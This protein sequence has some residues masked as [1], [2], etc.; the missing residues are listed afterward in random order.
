[1]Y[2]PKI[3]GRFPARKVIS[4]GSCG[5]G[6]I[7]LSSGRSLT[8][9]ILLKRQL[10]PLHMENPKSTV[11]PLKRSMLVLA[12][13]NPHKRL[14]VLL[15]S[16]IMWIG[17]LDNDNYLDIVYC[18]GTNTEKSYTFDGLQV[19]RIATKIRVKQGIVWGSYMG[20]YYDGV[21]QGRQP[22]ADQP[23]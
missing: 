9:E 21:F 2:H 17:D 6:G 5:G 10:K 22:T 13:F 19:N 15:L 14:Q 12:G 4:S 20:T 23:R 16:S 1:L 18:H 8:T 11:Y 3:D 7:K